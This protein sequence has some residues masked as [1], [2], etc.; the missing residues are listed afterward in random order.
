MFS[1]MLLSWKL[2]PIRSMHKALLPRSCSLLSRWTTGAKR[3]SVAVVCLALL[4]AATL[5]AA[6]ASPARAAP[7]AR[8]SAAAA[9]DSASGL[10]PRRLALLGGAGLGLHS[11]GFR[12][13]DRAWY[14]GQKQDHIRWINDWDGETYLNLDKGGHLMS[15][16]IMAQSMTDGLVWAGM[17]PVLSALVGTAISWGVLL[18]IEMRDAYYDQWGFSIPDFTANT[19]GASIPLLHTLIPQTRALQFKFS[20]HPSQLYRQRADRAADDRPH[21]DSMI[22]DYEGMT[23]WATLQVHPLLPPRMAA[24]WPEYLGVALGYGASGLH[25]ANVKSRGPNKYYDDLP[26]ARPEVYLALDYDARQLPGDGDLWAELKRQL[27]WIHLP[28]PALRLYPSLRFYLI[29]L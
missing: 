26:A 7:A 8:L 24:R 27:N 13:F 23:F 20:Y 18:E 10:K 11:L 15:G 17:S 28:A 25:G 5:N 22:D 3:H 9:A 4:V 6:G 14:L 21:T 19:L 12:Y 2:T 1:R 29:Y 16:C